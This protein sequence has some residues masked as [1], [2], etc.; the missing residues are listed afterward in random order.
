M[1]YMAVVNTLLFLFLF[2]FISFDE[3]QTAYDYLSNKLYFENLLLLHDPE[4]VNWNHSVFS[5]NCRVSYELNEKYRFILKDTTNWVPPMLE[6]AY[7][8]G[9]E[10]EPVAVVGKNITDTLIIENGQNYLDYHGQ[11]YRVVGVIGTDYFTS[12]DDMTIL[13]GGHIGDY[14]KGVLFIDSP[15][16]NCINRIE[17]Y[18]NEN[19]FGTKT[20]RG[21]I[22]GTARLTKTS[23]FFRMFYIEAALLAGLTL[24]AFGNQWNKKREKIRIVYF[25][26]GLPLFR[27]I[28]LEMVETVFANIFAFFFAIFVTAQIGIYGNTALERMFAI[29]G[30]LLGVSLVMI[31]L[32][33][34]SGMWR[35]RQGLCRLETRGR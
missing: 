10:G 13:F 7:P 16:S 21:N 27:E 8:N 20:E 11:Q 25:I 32:N 23:Y 30:M 2:A 35:T 3:Q 19:A 9:A 33:F 1:L 17:D 14:E 28:L 29:G 18:L 22:K 34:L 12:C 6:G 4:N 15:D 24:V 26:H 31:I 5:N